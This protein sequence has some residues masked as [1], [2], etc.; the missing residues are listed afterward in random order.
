MHKSKEIL[1]IGIGNIGR[2][3][4]ALAWHFL[5]QIESLYPNQ[6]TIEYRYQ[7]QIEDAHLI[8]NYRQV[9]FVD[10]YMLHHN[11]GYKWQKIKPKNTGTY[12]SHELLPE[13]VLFLCQEIYRKSP[14]THLLAIS[15]KNFGLSCTM[16]N[17]AQ[18]NLQK[19]LS[20]FVDTITSDTKKT[21]IILNNQDH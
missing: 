13:K 2:S 10:A 5:D 3:D 12:T 18:D 8:A 9:I 19:A 11:A 20:F 14:E 21:D 7:L 15:G 1:I 16:T 17:Y 6:Y 4:D